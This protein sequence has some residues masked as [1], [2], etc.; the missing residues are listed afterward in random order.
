[1]G[2][3]MGTH[4]GDK[5]WAKIRK[6]WNEKSFLAR[7]KLDKTKKDDKIKDRGNGY[8]K[9]K[10][11]SKNIRHASSLCEKIRREEKLQLKSVQIS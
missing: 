7:V 8:T 4:T 9:K 2:F 1:M 3:R 5:E 11:S 10:M 6:G